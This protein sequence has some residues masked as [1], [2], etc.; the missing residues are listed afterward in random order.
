MGLILFPPKVTISNFSQRQY[1]T[2]WTKFSSPFLFFR[3][4]H[5]RSTAPFQKDSV[6][7]TPQKPPVRRTRRPLR[8][9]HRRQRTKAGEGIQRYVNNAHY[10]LYYLTKGRKRMS[11]RDCCVAAPNPCENTQSALRCGYSGGD[12]DDGKEKPE[13]GFKGMKTMHIFIVL[14]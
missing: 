6:R 11:H 10:L 5:F 1:L 4:A 3:R 12:T 8:T 14:Y 9:R 2:N 13:K 7:R